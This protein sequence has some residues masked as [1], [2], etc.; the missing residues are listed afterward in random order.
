M[1]AV[2]FR[3]GKR[4]A[5]LQSRGKVEGKK[6]ERRS[7]AFSTSA[8]VKRSSDGRR[9]DTQLSSDRSESVFIA[10]RR[11]SSDLCCTVPHNQV[12]RRR[13]TKNRQRSGSGKFRHAFQSKNVLF[14][15]IEF[16]QLK[17]Q[18]VHVLIDSWTD[19]LID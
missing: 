10:V 15:L 4:T 9:D 7:Q 5:V 14:F 11:F 12:S 2:P 19:W 1:R 6:T 8:T 3:G 16:Y 13:H 17:Q 18:V